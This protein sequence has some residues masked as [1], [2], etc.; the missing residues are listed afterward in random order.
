VCFVD[1]FSDFPADLFE[2]IRRIAAEEGWPLNKA[3]ILLTKS[4]AKA[5]K[6]AE[7]SLPSAHEALINEADPQAVEKRGDDL[8]RVI[9]GPHAIG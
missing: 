3:V 6:E 1:N 2:E 9:F 8:I 7:Q 4:G 5:Q